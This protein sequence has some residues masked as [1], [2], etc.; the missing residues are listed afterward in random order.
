[1]RYWLILA[2]CLIFNLIGVHNAQACYTSGEWGPVYGPPVPVREPLEYSD[3]NGSFWIQTGPAT[4]AHAVAADPDPYAPGQYIITLTAGSPV[5]HINLTNCG[6]EQSD[7]PTAACIVNQPIDPNWQ[8]AGYLEIPGTSTRLYPYEETYDYKGA[9]I[10]ARYYT[11]YLS[12]Y[13]LPKKLTHV[14]N[15][16][17]AINLIKYPSAAY[18]EPSELIEKVDFNLSGGSGGGNPDPALSGLNKNPKAPE[19]ACSQV[20]PTPNGS[21]HQSQT[22]Y[23]D[24]CDAQ[25]GNYYHNE[26]DLALS[27]LL[28]IRMVR[29][30][31]S[32]LSEQI[33]EFGAG[34]YLATYNYRLS[35]PDSPD[36]NQETTLKLR[37]GPGQ[38]MAYTNGGSGTTFRNR[39]TTSTAGDSIAVTLNQSNVIQGF[40]YTNGEK[41]KFRFNTQGFLI[42]IED[43]SGNQVQLS[44]DSAGKLTGISAPESGRT[45]TIS[46]DGDDLISSIQDNTGRTVSYTYS[47]DKELVSVTNPAGQ[48]KQYT[49]DTQHRIVSGTDFNGNTKFTNEYDENG[50][51]SK[52][53]QAD[54][55]EIRL[56]TPSLT[57]RKVTDPNGHMITYRYNDQGLLTETENALGHTTKI[58][59]SPNLLTENTGN[60]FVE[61]QDPLERTT[62]IDLN[63][64]NHP[65]RVIDP[66]N[67]QAIVS[68][69]PVHSEKPKTITDPKG[70]V[71]QFEYDAAGHT[72][73]V[74]NNAGNNTAFT[75][76]AKG[77]VLTATDAMGNMTHFAYNAQNDLI[78]VTDPL[79]NKTLFEYDDLSRPV[80]ITDP[81]GNKT[82]LAYDAL[83]QLTS[84]TDALNRAK[85]FGYDSN[86]NKVSETDAKGHTTT[87]SYD[88]KDRLTS[89]TNAKGETYSYQYDGADNLMYVTDPKGQSTYNEF[90]IA[91]RLIRIVFDDN[92]EYVYTYDPAN[93]MV[94]VSDGS[95]TWG[96]TYDLLGRVT[97]ATSPQ[98]TVNYI[99]DA[100]GNVTQLTSP[101]YGTVLYTYDNLDRPTGITKDGKTF[102][103]AY[104]N[105]G[106]RTKLGRP[107]GVETLYSYDAASRLNTLTHKSPEMVGQNT[108]KI[109]E[110]Q[111]FSYDPAGNI[112]KITKSRGKLKNEVL[113]KNIVFEL[114]RIYQYDALNHLVNVKAI[115]ML[116]YASEFADTATRRQAAQLLEQARVA[117]NP[118]QRDSLIQQAE[119]LG[120][121]IPET[122][123]WAFDDNGNIQNKVTRKTGGST[124]SQTF[125]YDDAD[126]LVSIAKPSG[127][128][129]LNYDENGNLTSDSTGRSLTWNALDQLVQLN[130]PGQTYRMTYDP[131]G[132]RTSF[133]L[134]RKTDTF[135]Y[136]GL[137][138]LDD[139]KARFL[140][141]PGLDE[142]LQ[143]TNLKNG[144]SFTYLQD[145]LGSTSRLNNELG[146]ATKRLEYTAYGKLD[147]REDNPNLRNPFTYTGREDDGTGLMYYRARYYD[148]ELE[149]FI[150]QDPLGDAQRYVR[151]NPLNLVDPLGLWGG[152]LQLGAGGE[153]GFVNGT[154]GSISGGAAYFT[155]A[156]GSSIGTFASKGGFFGTSSIVPERH[157][158]P[159]QG[160]SLNNFALGAFG[161]GGVSLFFSPNANRAEDLYGPFDTYT[162]EF[163]A[164]LKVLNIQYSVDPKSG[165]SAFS[166][167]LPVGT[168]GVGVGAGFSTYRTNTFH[169]KTRLRF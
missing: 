79:G 157:N 22:S 148:P 104:D 18:Y 160:G 80:K 102:S 74:T 12:I 155:G 127:T 9:L 126:R 82:T 29:R 122:A 152:G 49:W 140:P 123:S 76:N 56:E 78:S 44:R 28:P 163:G 4:A 45:I 26:T 114:D 147:G 108:E 144:K 69:D 129:T 118:T 143:F 85:I 40:V 25:S 70:H 142:P 51:V 72:T 16:Y 128:I 62:H 5:Q 124:D 131:L 84:I 55:G 19:E 11:K 81:K 164:G 46:Y 13:P 17:A 154:A 100:N 20:S 65:I 68:Y 60:R 31:Y 41:D 94:S 93:Q 64:D 21:K 57:E 135:F 37:V 151:G 53:V 145:H 58:Q 2:F 95:G 33:G 6:G 138:L 119:A 107:N 83:D 23:A 43:R 75:Y 162:L 77:Q 136:D 169:A 113:K 27:S 71:T 133:A 96:F 48:G 103:F 111:Q 63:D 115:G 88:A 109:L 86:G 73:K 32:G 125:T 35:L 7:P 117:T 47:T 54:G 137:D 59:Y 42:A 161:G 87:F 24:P 139:G 168:P 146:V 39:S 150:S 120:A 10:Q 15:V 66:T 165:I 130:L 166:I 36:F 90:D 106:R 141:G 134:G 121:Y 101:S 67:Q 14:I 89:S 110:H 97:V 3:C 50:F 167:G 132:R 158:S 38:E 149:I 61:T 92:T 52:Q 30:Y 112:T 105:L 156:K 34:S 116:P 99:Y 153:I 8:D 1:M 98:G 91:D 159:C